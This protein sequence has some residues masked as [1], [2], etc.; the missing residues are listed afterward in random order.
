VVFEGDAEVINDDGSVTSLP[1]KSHVGAEGLKGRAY[2]S[3]VRAIASAEGEAVT[4]LV[5]D[6]Q[7][8]DNL[9]EASLS[10]RLREAALS[11]QQRKS[12]SE[13]MRRLSSEGGGVKD[14]RPRRLSVGQGMQSELP[15]DLSLGDLDILRVLGEG[16]YGR[17]KL[18]LHKETGFVLALK[19]MNKVMMMMMIFFRCCFL[20]F[21]IQSIVLTHTHIHTL[22]VSSLSLS[23]FFKIENLHP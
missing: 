10:D 17:V 8:L 14:R 21:F 4:C 9:G 20:Y 15:E 22:L 12:R 3:S 16:N 1:P 18:V 11:R 6:K 2:E 13:M 7:S 5:L 19:T 23:L